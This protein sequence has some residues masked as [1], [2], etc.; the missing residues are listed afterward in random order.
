VTPLQS[1]NGEVA[2]D[3]AIIVMEPELSGPP[4]GRV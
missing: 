4:P 1:M 2:A 3:G